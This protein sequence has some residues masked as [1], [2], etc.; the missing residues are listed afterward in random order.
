[1]SPR[2]V[3]VGILVAVALAGLAAILAGPLF[4]CAGVP[5]QQPAAAWVDAE[6]KTHD[7][8][9]PRLERYMAEDARREAFGEAPLL[10]LVERELLQGLLEDWDFRLSSR[11]QPGTLP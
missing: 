10:P 5:I 7:A 11:A 3:L 2:S 9:A 4:S 6:Q 8:I 1:M